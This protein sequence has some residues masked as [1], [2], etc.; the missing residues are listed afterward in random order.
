VK[1][2]FSSINRRNAAINFAAVA[3]VVG[4]GIWTITSWR[5]PSN[6]PDIPFAPL[7]DSSIKDPDNPIKVFR[8]DFARVEE[9]FPLSHTDLMKISPENIAVLSAEQIDQIYGRITTGPI[10]DGPYEGNVFVG[11]GNNLQ[12][13]INGIIGGIEG[14]VVGEGINVLEKIGR[15]I[16]KGKHFYREERVV[17]NFIE[18]YVPLR[19]VIDNPSTLMIATIPRHGILSLLTPIDK[20]WMLFPAKLY[21]GQSLLDSRRESAIIDYNY[22]DEIVGYRENPDSLAGRNGLKI[23]EE[24]RMIRPGFYLGRMYSNRMFVAYFTLF[25]ADVAEREA[26]KFAAGMPSGDD[27]WPGE[28]AR[29]A[30]I[31]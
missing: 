19:A 20:V 16:W 13:R 24:I 1:N 5:S 15:R 26:T 17:R 18:N 3:I 2:I 9:E 25:N 31:K 7:E 30:A 23:R 8:V 14:R 6:P 21:C 10:P 29:R 28:Q 22:N 27:C 4:V 11:L 12:N